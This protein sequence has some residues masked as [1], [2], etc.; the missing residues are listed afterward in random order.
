MSSVNSETSGRILSNSGMQIGSE[1]E[2]QQINHIAC[3][4]DI[5]SARPV[6]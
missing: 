1:H 5:T 3:Q 2:G 4:A 6:A